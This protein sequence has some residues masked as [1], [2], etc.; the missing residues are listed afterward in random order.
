MRRKL[1]NWKMDSLSL[2]GRRVLVQSNLATMPVYTTQALALIVGTFKDIDKICRDFLW[3][4][5]ESRKKVHLVNWNEVCAH[6]T[7]GGLGLRKA[8]DFNMALL[9]KLA[10]QVLNCPEKLWVKVI[11]DK[12][13]KNGNFFTAPVPSHSSWSWRSIV[14]RRVVIKL[15]G[16]W[17]IGNGKSLNFLFD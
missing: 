6:K 15:G 13:I 4:D 8:V 14:K 5:S 9:A 16:S 17:R 10:W 7:K 1:A 12:Y 2:A 3:G 11:H